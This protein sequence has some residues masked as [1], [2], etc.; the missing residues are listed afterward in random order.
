ML[1]FDVR[2]NGTSLCRAGVGKAGVLT[3]TVSWVGGSPEAA[4]PG[5]RTEQG[6]TEL[7]VG[8]LVTANGDHIFLKWLTRALAPGDEVKLRVVEAD[9]V[10]PPASKVV[11][12]RNWVE[13]QEKAYYE[14]MKR[15]Y[16]RSAQKHPSAAGKR[17]GPRKR[18]NNQ[19]QRTRSAAAKRRGPRR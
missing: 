19:M 9:V 18:S 16:E 17:Q 10:D 13:K 12:K 5:G 11:E 7:D 15:K 4:R 6:E 8:G 1:S 3:A 2:L 14:K